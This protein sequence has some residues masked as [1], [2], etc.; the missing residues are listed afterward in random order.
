[1]RSKVLDIYSHNAII[2]AATPLLMIG[3]FLLA[4]GAGIGTLAFFLGA[5][6]IGTGLNGAGR[7][8]TM[9]LTTQKG[10]ELAIGIA[11]IGMG[12]AS[13]LLGNHAPLALLLI[14]FGS[15]LLGLS[16]ITRYTAPAN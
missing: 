11:L 13:G 8:R 15:A 6:L 3:P 5:I 14:G 10:L 2:L 4:A 1:M 12:I 16:S 7:G 9:P